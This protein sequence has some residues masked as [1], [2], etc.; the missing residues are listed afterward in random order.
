MKFPCNSNNVG[1]ELQCD[2]CWERGKTMVYEGETSRSARI[3]GREHL[4][5]LEG[6][7]IWGKFTQTQ[8]N[9]TQK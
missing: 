7:E 5:D 4:S 2:T 6:G 9:R 8:G 1:Y 3:R